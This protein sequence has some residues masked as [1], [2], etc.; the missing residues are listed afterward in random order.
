M[1]YKS[2]IIKFVRSSEYIVHDTYELVIF[3][4][5]KCIDILIDDKTSND[6]FVKLASIIIDL[7]YTNVPDLV[8]K[9]LNHKVKKDW[10]KQI[11]PHAQLSSQNI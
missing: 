1:A 10:L 3:N 6:Q 9:T 2:F 11:C 8:Y 5:D 7:K 4:L